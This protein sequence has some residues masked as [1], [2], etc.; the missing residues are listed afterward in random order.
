MSTRVQAYRQSRFVATLRA[1]DLIEHSLAYDKLNTNCADLY[2][3]V[4]KC[5][6][7]ANFRNLTSKLIRSVEAQNFRYAF[8]AVDV[9]SKITSRVFRTHPLAYAIN[10]F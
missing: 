4:R 1:L 8:N 2:Y 5:S 10:P 3:V 7:L 6:Q 9:E